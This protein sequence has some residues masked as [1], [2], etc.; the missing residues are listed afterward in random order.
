M[1]DREADGAKEI[2]S[3][4][5]P[6]LAVIQKGITK[7]PRIPS[8]R[9]IMSART[10]PLIV[11]EPLDIGALTEFQGYELPQPKAACKM[12]DPENVKELIN[13]LKNEAK[14]L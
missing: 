2:L 13:L 14:I 1:I 12:I 10:K 11:K 8:M 9:G 6:F 3:I 4:T 5:L 7:E